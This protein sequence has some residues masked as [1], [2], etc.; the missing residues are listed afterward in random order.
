VAGI[1]RQPWDMDLVVWPNRGDG[2]L[3]APTAVPTGNVPFRE[4]VAG[5]LDGD[6]HLDL[7][8]AVEDQSAR[9]VG[10]LLGTGGGAFAPPASYETGLYEPD[11]VL[12]LTLADVD[13]DGALDV[14][15]SNGRRAAGE[16]NVFTLLNDGAGA[17][18]PAQVSEAPGVVTGLAGGDF[19]G[20]GTLDVATDQ[21]VL[22]GAGDGTFPEH[23]R[24]A[25][26]SRP[27]A[28]DLDGDAA[29]DLAYV[30][31]GQDRLV[32][33]LNALADEG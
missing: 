20:D 33:M 18:G 14:A 2:T 4:V 8:L 29:P 5:D 27:L 25:G 22:F 9:R 6:G 19:D 11:T 10:V 3:D 13:G 16:P 12:T 32:V 28:A 31:V 30:P 21:A 26:D 7:A 17:F 15:G 23:R 24:V 1:G